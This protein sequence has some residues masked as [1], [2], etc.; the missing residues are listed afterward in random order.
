MP[1]E[2]TMPGDDATRCCPRT[3]DRLVGRR[4]IV[5]AD[6]GDDLERLG[7]HRQHPSPR[8]EQP[9]DEVEALDGVAEQLPDRDDHEVAERVTVEVPGA[10]E[11]VLQ[12]VAPGVAPV[13]V[14]AQRGE[15][16]AQVARRQDV[17]LVAQPAARPAVVGDRDD[18]GHVVGEQAQRSECSGEPVASAESDDA[19][20]VRSADSRAG[21]RHRHSRPRSRWTMNV[22]TPSGWPIRAL[23]ASAVATERCLPP[24]QPT[25]TVT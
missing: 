21:R 5:A 15:R 19:A 4:G 9:A 20:V 11:A 14:V 3:L 7:R 8:A 24:V 13:A 16:H 10:R 12:H 2:D 1:I 6:L 25:A 18:G 17:E 22:S 23:S